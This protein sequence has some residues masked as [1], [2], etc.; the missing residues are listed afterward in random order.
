MLRKILFYIIEMALVYI[1]IM[2]FVMQ[3]MFHNRHLQLS[4]EFTVIIIFFIGLY[5]ME[6]FLRYKHHSCLK[7]GINDKFLLWC[8]L[9]G[10]YLLLAIICDFHIS[11]NILAMIVISIFMRC[12]KE[13][14][15]SALSCSKEDIKRKREKSK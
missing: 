8:F 15:N 4:G 6:Y 3:S 9:N 13:N 11:N 12:N 10:L 1:F 14:I 7:L 2:L 5:V